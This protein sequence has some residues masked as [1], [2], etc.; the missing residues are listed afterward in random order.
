MGEIADD[1]VQGACCSQCGI[2]FDGEHGYP[3]L[4][5]GCWNAATPKEREG[6]QKA[7]LEEF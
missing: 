1:M 6:L 4:C 2:Y 7:H 3:V 5:A